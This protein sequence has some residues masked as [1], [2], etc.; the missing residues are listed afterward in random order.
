M[1]GS[2]SLSMTI[3]ATSTAGTTLLNRTLSKT[4]SFGDLTKFAENVEIGTSTTKTLLDLTDTS[5]S[6]LLTP[7]GGAADF[8][9]LLIYVEDAEDADDIVFLEATTDVG[10]EVGTE[11][12]PPIALRKGHWFVL[13]RSG[14]YA[15]YTANFG[16]GTVDNIERIRVRN[17]SAG[18]VAKVSIYAFN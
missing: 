10:A 6:S 7:S 18:T 16:G 17:I 2:L 8:D 14:S 5:D 3:T 12:F 4:I 11:V 13:P 1:A 15:N 9:Y